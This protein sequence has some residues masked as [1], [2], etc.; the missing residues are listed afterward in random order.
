MLVLFNNI[1]Q[2]KAEKEARLL[3]GGTKNEDIFQEVPEGFVSLSP[4][5]LSRDWDGALGGKQWHCQQLVPSSAEGRKRE[6]PL[7]VSEWIREA[8]Y[9]WEV[10]VGEKENRECAAV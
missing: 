4:P 9:A 5:S 6:V 10:K 3:K 8:D 1:P 2:T 7:N